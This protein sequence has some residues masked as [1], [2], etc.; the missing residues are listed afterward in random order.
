MPL[1]PESMKEDRLQ[2]SVVS[3]FGNEWDKFK[4]EI[5]DD[6][7]LMFGEYFSIFPWSALP[8]NATGC[9][10]GCG[11]GR[12]AFFVAPRVGHLY[13][14][15]PSEKALA[16]AEQKLSVYNNCSFLMEP[17]DSISIPNASLD[18]GYCLGVLHHVTNTAQSLR[19]IV[20]KLKAGAPFLLYLYYR[21]ENRPA[22]FRLI[23]RL[24]N[25]PRIFVSALPF[26]LKSLICEIIAA[27]IY[28]PAARLAGLLEKLGVNVSAVPLSYYRDKSFYILRNDALDRFGTKL[29]KRF[30]RFAIEAMMK[31]AGLFNISFRDG[32]PYW[33]AVGFKS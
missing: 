13:C 26:R 7:R 1:H 8:P 9:D 16:V 11:S 30:T 3:S 5:T 2:N 23:W 6:Q 29:E 15:D 21:L 32:A 4:N 33:V 25:I 14:I 28:W 10:V 18:F 27:L 24:S 20:Q 17:A 31:D 22:W 19:H 12:F